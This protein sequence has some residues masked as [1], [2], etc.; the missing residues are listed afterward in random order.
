MRIVLLIVFALSHH[1]AK[2][3]SAEKSS[4]DLIREMAQRP[5]VVAGTCGEF[6]YAAER[7]QADLE[8]LVRFGAPAIPAVDA[9]LGS[10][11]E[12]GQGSEFVNIGG[13]LLIAGARL[14][15]AAAF[16]RLRQMRGDPHFTGYSALDTAATISLGLTSYIRPVSLMPEFRQGGDNVCGGPSSI[17]CLGDGRSCTAERNPG[18]K[19]KSRTGFPA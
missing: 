15:G 14:K 19:C 3:Q 5:P 8:S 1:A 17:T 13:P 6:H 10:I 7:D 9:A 18:T 11:D 4:S 12:K 16:P 2:G